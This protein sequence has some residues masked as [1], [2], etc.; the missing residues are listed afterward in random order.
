MKPVT[1]FAAL[2]LL[3]A[4]NAYAQ[5]DAEQRVLSK[6][7][8]PGGV[9][10]SELIAQTERRP[11]FYAIESVSFSDSDGQYEVIYFMEDGAEVRINSDAATGSPRPPK[12][13]L[14]GG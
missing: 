6:L 1:V 5:D 13:G 12:R 3:L 4:G 14:F 10:L 8:P 7:P 2:T 9:K 11:G